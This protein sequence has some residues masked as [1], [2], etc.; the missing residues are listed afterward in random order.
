MTENNPRRNRNVPSSPSFGKEVA[1]FAANTAANEIGKAV[2]KTVTDLLN[3]PG[4]QFVSGIPINRWR[5]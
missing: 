1:D 3:V 5:F 2:A 4:E